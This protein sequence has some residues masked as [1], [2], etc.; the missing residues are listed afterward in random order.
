MTSAL[1]SVLVVGEHPGLLLNVVRML[2]LAGVGSEVASPAV[3]PPVRWSRYCRR[4]VKIPSG[5]GDAALAA[6]SSEI[7]LR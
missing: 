1:P 6:K 3:A 4:V 7:G 2:D 5:W